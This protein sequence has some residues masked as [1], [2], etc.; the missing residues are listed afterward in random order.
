MEYKSN[1]ISMTPQ[2]IVK[3][4]RERKKSLEYSNQKL[5]NLSGVP[6]GTI[7]RIMSG[8]YTEFKYSSIQP[9]VATLL[10]FKEE[11]PEPQK[12]ND[13]QARYYYDTIEGYKLVLE[14]KNRE[15]EN[16][17]KELEQAII[18]KE[19]L[20][21]EN[22]IKEEHLKWMETVIDDIKKQKRSN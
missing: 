18:A 2:D 19:Y 22:A 14:N 3:W 21:R 13:K 16:I 15:I 11:T 20:K 17:K 8:N 4:C 7:D 5:A 10:G 1:I 6:I 9:I 12:E